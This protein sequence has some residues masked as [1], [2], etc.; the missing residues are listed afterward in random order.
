MKLKIDGN[1]VAILQDGKPLYVQDD[2][3]EIAFDAGQAFET[4]KTL[5]NEAKTYREERDALKKKVQDFSGI[6]DPAKAAKAIQFMESMNGKTAMDDEA[7]QKLIN[8]AVKPLQEQ[9]A[10][11]D[12]AI[13]EL[14]GNL[15]KLQVSNRFA[16]SNYLKEKTTL[17]PD[18]AEAYF[19][20]NMKYENGKFVAV[21]GKGE[22][23]FSRVKAGETADFD[24]AIQ[25]LI[26]SHPMK[27]HLLRASG[28][29]GSGATGS[30]GTGGR[31]ETNLSSRDKI[32]AGLIAAGVS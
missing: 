32:K 8:S 2:G 23:I 14:D 3:T 4:A 18:I 15:Y 29:S 17:I 7:I 22:Q 16:S 12:K 9:L 10:D 13:L 20:K 11:K 19:G 24:E 1:G 6:D 25:I 30:N 27:D 5:R 26:E 21:D 28:A 31:Q